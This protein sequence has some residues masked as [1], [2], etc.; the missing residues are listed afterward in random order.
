MANLHNVKLGAD[1]KAS[2]EEKTSNQIASVAS[3]I[4]HSDLHNFLAEQQRVTL[5]EVIYPLVL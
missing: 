1:L 3:P 5:Q 2:F 4:Q